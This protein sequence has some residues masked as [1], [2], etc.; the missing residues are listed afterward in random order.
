[1]PPDAFERLAQRILRESG[2]IKVEVK[3]KS[4]DGGIDGIGVLR[5]NLLVLSG[6]LPVQT[7]Q[8]T[9]SADLVATFILGDLQW[10]ISN[11]HR[12]LIFNIVRKA[13]DALEEYCLAA[14]S[15]KNH[16]NPPMW[17]NLDHYFDALRRFEHC[18]AHSLRSGR[19]YQSPEQVF[20]WTEAVRS[21]RWIYP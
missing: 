18:L 19:L 13:E 17:R 9:T 21:R 12:Q 3:G 2:F 15:L 6:I 7:L 5:V 16:V 20:E 1:M 8:K 10:V 4:G 14:E 11:R